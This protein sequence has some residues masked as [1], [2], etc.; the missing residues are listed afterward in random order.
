MTTKRIVLKPRHGQMVNP[1]LTPDYLKA[2]LESSEIPV[3]SVY[4]NRHGACVA[5]AEG[6]EIILQ[7]F[8]DGKRGTIVAFITREKPTENTGISGEGDSQPD[9]VSA[10][11]GDYL[12]PDGFS[13][14]PPR[15]SD[16][17]IKDAV[18]CIGLVPKNPR[19]TQYLF[20]CTINSSF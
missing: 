13:L 6:L 3:D 12:P 20:C 1:D 18:K 19:G 2:M 9:G 5:L 17:E 14:P 10:R 16:K 15:V 4:T 8:P 11:G 7:S